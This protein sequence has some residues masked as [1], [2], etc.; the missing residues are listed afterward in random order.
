MLIEFTVFTISPPSLR[1]W[2]NKMIR[3]PFEDPVTLQYLAGLGS[4]MA[5]NQDMIYN[6]IYQMIY[7]AVLFLT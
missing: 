4:C 6:I 3:W 7:D 5:L 1:N 2:L